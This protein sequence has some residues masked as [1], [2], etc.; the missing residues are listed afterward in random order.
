[1][2][3]FFSHSWMSEKYLTENIGLGAKALST[4]TSPFEFI[5]TNLQATS[6][7]ASSEGKIPEPSSSPT[8]PS[9]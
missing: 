8:E 9:R 7:T 1:M 5:K 3:S 2:F 4:I 6:L